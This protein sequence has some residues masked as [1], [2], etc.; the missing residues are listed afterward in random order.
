MD[1]AE[2]KAMKKAAKKS[3]REIRKTADRER[4]K[5][6]LVTCPSS[7]H[8]HTMAEALWKDGHYT[9]FGEEPKHCAESMYAVLA[10]LWAARHRIIELE[11]AASS[12]E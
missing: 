8:V 2:L 7:R 11:Q 6:P 1:D 4:A 9:M 10:C 5:A 3:W 12:G